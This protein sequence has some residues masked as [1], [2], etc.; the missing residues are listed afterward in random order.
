MYFVFDLLVYMLLIAAYLHLVVN[1]LC[2]M[3]SI[4]AIEEDV[5]V[6]DLQVLVSAADHI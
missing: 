2:N 6:E 4:V 1:P 3:D 5:T